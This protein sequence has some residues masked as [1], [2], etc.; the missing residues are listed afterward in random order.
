MKQHLHGFMLMVMIVM[1]VQPYIMNI[2]LEE[3][4]SHRQ[5]SLCNP[6]KRH[7]RGTL[8]MAIDGDHCLCKRCL[9]C[10]HGPALAVSYACRLMSMDCLFVMHV[11]Q[12]AVA[13]PDKRKV[14][15]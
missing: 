1:T 5:C 9:F 15:R 2:M 4:S 13:I 11:L 7:R 8:E 14:C 6:T 12:T 10:L 3:P